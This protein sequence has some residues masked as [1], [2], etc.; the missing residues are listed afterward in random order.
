MPSRD[1]EQHL[2]DILEGIELIE[3]F[4]SGMDMNG[5]EA[6]VLRRSAVERQMQIITEATKRL[7]D[8]AYVVCPH[9][10]WKGFCRMGDILRMAITR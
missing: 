7:G 10:D 4:T 8:D 2:R 3:S 9:E 1:N 6:D 5:Y